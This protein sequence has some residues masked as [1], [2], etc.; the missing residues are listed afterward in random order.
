M[1]RRTLLLSAR[2]KR[3]NS[4]S[5]TPFLAVKTTGEMPVP[6]FRHGLSQSRL[7]LIAVL[8]N[9]ARWTV[10]RILTDRRLAM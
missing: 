2:G 10:G 9:F 6:Q 7:C 8:T 4:R 1:F 3:E 5:E